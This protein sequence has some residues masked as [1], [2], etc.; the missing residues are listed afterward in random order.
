MSVSFLFALA[1]RLEIIRI[2]PYTFN[3][4]NFSIKNYTG[5]YM[6]Y[7]ITDNTLI[8]VKLYTI[9]YYKLIFVNY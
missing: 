3:Y 8:I 1:L 5:I 9:I 2:S 6:L 7:S 4:V